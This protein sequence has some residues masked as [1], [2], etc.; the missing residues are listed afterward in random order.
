MSYDALIEQL[1]AAY[2]ARVD[3]REEMTIHGWKRRERKRFLERLRAE[4]RFTLVDL[5]AGT[6]G[7][8]HR[9]AHAGLEV[10][11]VDL[12]PAMVAAC[13]QRASKL[14]AR[15][16]SACT[17]PRPFDADFA[18]NCLLHVPSKSCPRPCARLP[19]C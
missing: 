7:H 3:Q 14:T 2:D 6:G 10:V 15:T 9:F 11:C 16:F 4:D 8:G 12:S 17:Y 5:G 19:G 13:Q 18:L 1:R